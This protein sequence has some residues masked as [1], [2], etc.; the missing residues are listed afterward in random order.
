[1][2]YGSNTIV[3]TIAVEVTVQQQRHVIHGHNN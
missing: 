1:M 3:D 2:V